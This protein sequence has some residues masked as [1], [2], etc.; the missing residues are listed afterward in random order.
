MGRQGA[1]L[2]FELEALLGAPVHV[3][4]EGGMSDEQREHVLAEANSL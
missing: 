2:H 3:V 1:D 4:T